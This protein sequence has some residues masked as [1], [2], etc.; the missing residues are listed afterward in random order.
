LLLVT[1]CI[2]V[3]LVREQRFHHMKSVDSLPANVVR[4]LLAFCPEFFRQPCVEGLRGGLGIAGYALG[5]LGV[6]L[7]LA[8]A[9]HLFRRG[10]RVIRFALLLALL[11]TALPVLTT[12]LQMRHVYVATAFVACLLAAWFQE[13]SSRSRKL[14]LIGLLG[15]WTFDQV[16]D[17]LEY[18]EAGAVS[19]TLLAQVMAAG[20]EAGE[21]TPVALVEA[22]YWW[23]NERDI[24]FFN[25]GMRKALT[26]AGGRNPWQAVKVSRHYFTTDLEQITSAQLRHL[27]RSSPGPVLRYVE[28][29]RSYQPYQ[30]DPP[31]DHRGR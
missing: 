11:E 21:S 13:R 12:G 24:P 14:I 10:N 17:V 16:R 6:F 25:Y 5:S 29:T 3:A 1:Y 18:R 19:N 8:T 23:G 4:G 20:K 9:M 27:V 26:M 28:A 15:L 7:V 2:Y 22:P 31:P 30:E